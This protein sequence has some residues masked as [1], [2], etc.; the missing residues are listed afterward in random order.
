MQLAGG[1]D[2]AMPNVSQLAVGRG[3]AGPKAAK[4]ILLE[5]VS[6]YVRPPMEKLSGEAGPGAKPQCHAN[7]LLQ[8]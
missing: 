1:R 5:P 6:Q 3:R 4:P 7:A 8:R 2:K